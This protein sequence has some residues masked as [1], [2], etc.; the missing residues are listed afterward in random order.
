[1]WT[2]AALPYMDIYESAARNLKIKPPSHSVPLPPHQPPGPYVAG[3]IVAEPKLLSSCCI[4]WN[5]LCCQNHLLLR[6][7]DKC[8]ENKSRI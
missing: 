8:L 6:T 5:S 7:R 1:M 2:K 3:P 4:H